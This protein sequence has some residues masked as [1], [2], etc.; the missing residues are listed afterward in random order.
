MTGQEAV[1]GLRRRGLKPQAVF[2]EPR[3]PTA[4]PSLSSADKAPRSKP[5]DQ[6]PD[7][8]PSVYAGDTQPAV[9]DLRFLVGLRVHLCPAGDEWTWAGWWDAIVAAKP[10]E[11]FGVHPVTQELSI[12]RP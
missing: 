6:A 3:H 12:W 5:T 1:I 2:F 9:A 7:P 11:L 4:S 8:L 10:S